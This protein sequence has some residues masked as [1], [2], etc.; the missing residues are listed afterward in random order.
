MRNH[1]VPQFL[2]RPWTT[3]RKGELISYHLHGGKVHATAKVPK[4]VGFQHDMLSL[5][6]VDK[7][8]MLGEQ[9]SLRLVDRAALPIDFTF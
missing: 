6:G 3:G 4:S 1:Y 2:Q 5:G 7:L 8:A 9:V